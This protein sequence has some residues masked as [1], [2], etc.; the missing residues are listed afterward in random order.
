MS[1]APTAADAPP[2]ARWRGP[3][4]EGSPAGPRGRAPFRVGGQDIVMVSGLA[5]LGLLIVLPLLALVAQA[6]F[7]RLFARHPSLLF[8]AASLIRVLHTPY[9]FRML[10]DSMLMSAGAGLAA[11]LVGGV[12]ALV[13][14]R[15][16]LPGRGLWHGLVWCT[17]LLPSFLLAEGWTFLLQPS[18]LLS[19]VL[20]EP[21]WL[22]NIFGNPWGVGTILALK[23]F[24]F[25][26]LSVTAALPW[27]GGEQEAVARTL[28]AS[29]WGVWRRIYLPLLV[30]FFASGAAIVFADVLSDFGVAI[31]VA[32]S[33]Q[34]PLLTYG[35]YSAMYN[36]PTDFGGAGALSLLLTLAVGLAILLQFVFLRRGRFATIHSGYRPPEP[37]RLGRWRWPLLAGVAAFFA[38][39]LG[40]PAGSILVESLSKSLSFGMGS[41]ALTFSNYAALASQVGAQGVTALG[42]S[43]RLAV[44]TATGAVLLGT[45]LAYLGT[46]GAG[47]L[48]PLLE[49][50][51]LWT[52]SIPGIILASGYVFLWNQPWLE[53]VHLNLYGTVWAL[54][55]AYLAGGI[56]YVLRFQ[57]GALAQLDRRLLS[58][59]RVL[60]AGIGRLLGRIVLPLVAEGALALWLFVLAGTAF[61]LPA[62]EFLYPPGHPT[63]AIEVNHFFNTELYGVGTALAVTA[64]VLLIVLVL[65]LRTLVARLLPGPGRRGGNVRRLG[66]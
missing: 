54:T 48:G 32:E 64:A 27:I 30:P 17:L 55:L 11:A 25:A 3:A 7:P 26:F 36:I 45:L 16:D 2:A 57:M 44:I 42:Y 53:R 33:H 12:L 13:I 28:G 43:M 38:L 60:G 37:T 22:P 19:R 59:A 62:S 6:V 49:G 21:A 47:R 23:F 1:V 50:V 34:F 41:Y 5:A 31:T 10:A 8:N 39:A 29:R 61:E 63:L 15:T 18:G 40:L 58:A 24:P 56:P 9:D 65:V 35:I 20:P 51:S 52:I 4:G 14:V 66:P 46:H